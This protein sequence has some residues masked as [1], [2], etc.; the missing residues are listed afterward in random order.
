MLGELGAE[1]D[2]EPVARRPRRR[3][4]RAPPWLAA[5]GERLVEEVAVGRHL[6]GLQDQRRIGGAIG[7]LRRRI[8]LDVAGVGDHDRHGPQLVEFRGHGSL[9]L[10]RFRHV[11]RSDAPV[12]PHSVPPP[13]STSAGAGGL[14]CVVRAWRPL[15]VA[16]GRAAL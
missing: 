8:G 10:R 1:V 9:P 11:G 13:H 5:P 6:G 4:S 3:A 14:S 7:G 2:R 12:K 15:A 16:N